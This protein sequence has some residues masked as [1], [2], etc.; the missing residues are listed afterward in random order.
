MDMCAV[1]LSMNMLNHK[2]CV[3]VDVDEHGHFLWT[4]RTCSIHVVLRDNETEVEKYRKEQREDVRRKAS[5][6][7]TNMEVRFM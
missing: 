3:D 6:N 1:R 4:V 7:T 2:N 5:T